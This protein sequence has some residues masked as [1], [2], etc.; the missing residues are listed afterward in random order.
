M[1]YDSVS[2][3]I[4]FLNRDKDDGERRSAVSGKKVSLRLSLGLSNITPYTTIFCFL[5]SLPSSDVFGYRFCWRLTSPK[6]TKLQRAKEM[7]CLSS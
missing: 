5:F 3:M 2:F 1:F 6:R 7:N 4:Q